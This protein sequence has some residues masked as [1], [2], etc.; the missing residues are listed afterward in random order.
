MKFKSG[1]EQSIYIVLIL[2]RVPHDYYITSEDISARLKL[3]PSYTKKL[4]KDLVHEGLIKST[5]GK[6]G[7]FSLARPL[8]EIDLSNIF[9]AIE[10]RGSLFSET[11]LAAHLTGN[12]DTT[13]KCSLKVVL[14]T[15]EG[16]WRSLL[17][18]I[19][20]NDLE[21]KVEQEHDMSNIDEWIKS[22]ILK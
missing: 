14:D 12:Y 20:L 5:P 19:N 16:T 9:D 6:K 8:S 3:S 7:G 18:S 4:M 2:G 13:Q 21:K 17:K 1:I 15:I 22:V 10:G 11:E